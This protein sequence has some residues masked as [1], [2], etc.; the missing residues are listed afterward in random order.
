[1]TMTKEELNSTT[2][3]FQAALKTIFP[4]SQFK[5]RTGLINKD[6]EIRKVEQ[7]TLDSYMDESES[8]LP[9]RENI[10]FYI[11]IHPS[12][13]QRHL[14]ADTWLSVYKKLVVV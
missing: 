9:S 8:T 12:Q 10:N 7:K 6:F 11:T 4:N 13:M 1:M 2:E 5:V 14:I 3:L